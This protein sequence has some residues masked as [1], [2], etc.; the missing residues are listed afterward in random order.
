MTCPPHPEPSE[1]LETTS[2]EWMERSVD[3]THVIEWNLSGIDMPDRTEP[4]KDV[5]RIFL[6]PNDRHRQDRDDN[7]DWE[8]WD[9]VINHSCD[10]GTTKAIHLPFNWFLW[11]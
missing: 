10:D 6:S 11:T 1:I 9:W 2:Y 7:D 4:M 8:Y 5:W 3:P